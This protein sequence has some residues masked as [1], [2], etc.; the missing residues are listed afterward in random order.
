MKINIQKTDCQFSGEENKKFRLEVVGQELDQTE[1]VVYLEGNTSTQKG[2]DTGCGK[3][4]SVGEGKVAG[5]GEGVEL[6]GTEQDH[7]DTHVHV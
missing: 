4:N 2:S 5:A 1:N 7:K 3:K 6:Q